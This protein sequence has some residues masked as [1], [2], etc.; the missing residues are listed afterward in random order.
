MEAITQ[1]P[2]PVN[3]PVRSYAPGTSERASLKSEL[4]GLLAAGPIEVA[5]VVNGA[6]RAAQS[7]D[8]YQVRMPSDHGTLLACV[9]Q[10]TADDAVAAVEAAGRAK[11]DWAAMSFDDRAAIFLRAAE[12]LAGPWRDRLNASTMLLSLIHI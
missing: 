9:S 12:L 4:D 3:E 10:A 8:R 7:S 5:P 6:V 2:T 1:V 11:Q